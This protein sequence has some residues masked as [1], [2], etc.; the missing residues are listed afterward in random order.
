MSLF[1][2]LTT[3]II[4]VVTWWYNGVFFLDVTVVCH[5]SLHAFI[6]EKKVFYA[7]SLDV[8]IELKKHGDKV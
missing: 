6:L 8:G 2:G 1:T 3:C 7:I 4:H 5:R